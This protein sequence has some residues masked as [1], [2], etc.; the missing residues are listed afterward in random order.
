[1][2]RR[3]TQA[4]IY[5]GAHGSAGAVNGSLSGTLHNRYSRIRIGARRLAVVI[6]MD[7][8]LLLVWSTGPVPPA[9]RRM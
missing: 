1:M 3:S 7:A 4:T 8:H 5:A 9:G 6:L 2:F